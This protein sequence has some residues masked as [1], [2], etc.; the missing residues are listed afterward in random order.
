MLDTIFLA[1]DLIIISDT[2][3]VL[4]KAANFLEELSNTYNLKDLKKKDPK[5]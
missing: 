1:D 3:V 4:Q 2:Q 5:L